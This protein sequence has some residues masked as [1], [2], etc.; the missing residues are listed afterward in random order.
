[1]SDQKSEQRESLME[2]PF[3]HP[4]IL[5]ELTKLLK[6]RGVVTSEDLQFLH[7]NYKHLNSE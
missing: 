5:F 3:V 4:V 6:E 7:K 2:E 1:M